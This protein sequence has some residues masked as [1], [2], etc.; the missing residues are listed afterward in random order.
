MEKISVRVTNWEN[1]YKVVHKNSILK[2][3]YMTREDRRFKIYI[4]DPCLLTQGNILEK[5]TSKTLMVV[6]L[7]YDMQHLLDF[8]FLLGK[9]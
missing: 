3:K 8:L 2:Y 6:D 4:L 9:Q 1:L 7:K 5:R